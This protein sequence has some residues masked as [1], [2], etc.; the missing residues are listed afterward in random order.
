MTT[1]TVSAPVTISRDLLGG[2]GFKPQSSQ[3][4]PPEGKHTVR[5]DELEVADGKD[6]GTKRITAKQ[7][8]IGGEYDGK[9]V[10]DTMFFPDFAKSTKNRD[11]LA[12][13]LYAYNVTDEEFAAMETADGYDVTA[14]DFSGRE[15]K[16]NVVYK[17]DDEKDKDYTNV[18]YDRQKV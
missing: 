7:T 14:V 3:Y 1:A 13:I 2:G 4:R 8:I 10:R 11:K 15:C 12:A 6:E 5:L 9:P 18:Y 17:H 16:A